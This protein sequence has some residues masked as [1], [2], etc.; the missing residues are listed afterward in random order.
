MHR[1]TRDDCLR[2]R[3]Y[4]A[5]VIAAREEYEIRKEEIAKEEARGCGTR[6]GWTLH[7]RRGE[8]PCLDCDEAYR[9]FYREYRRGQRAKA[10]TA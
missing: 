5:E 7:K 4:T 2:I 8:Y 9:A 1:L 6:N 10:R 3:Q